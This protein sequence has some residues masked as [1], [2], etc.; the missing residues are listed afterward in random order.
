MNLNTLTKSIY[1]L[2]F[3]S[4]L[5]NS[6]NGQEN[7]TDLLKEPLWSMSNLGYIKVDH[8]ET[9]P[10]GWIRDN[11]DISHKI[12][13]LITSDSVV[14][15]QELDQKLTTKKDQEIKH[16]KALLLGLFLFPY[17]LF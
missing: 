9:E 7:T 17:R 13:L 8:G 6:C 1:R 15:C 12:W 11:A 16:P 5:F 3:L 2:L 14:Q 4:V 10:T